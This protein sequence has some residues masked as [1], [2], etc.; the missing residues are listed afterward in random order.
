ME[1]RFDNAS[2]VVPGSYAI[3]KAVLVKEPGRLPRRFVVTYVKRYEVAGLSASL[4]GLG[5]HPLAIYDQEVG[6]HLLCLYLR[7]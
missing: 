1:S 2:C 7:S 5:W 3:E 6:N 4:Q